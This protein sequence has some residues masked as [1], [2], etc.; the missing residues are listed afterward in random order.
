MRQ[1]TEPPP[2]EPEPDPIPATSPPEPTVRKFRLKRS[3][4]M[5]DDLTGP[6]P[7]DQAPLR[8]PQY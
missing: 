4:Q 5:H 8:P 3:G 7:D 2:P 1:E 6:F